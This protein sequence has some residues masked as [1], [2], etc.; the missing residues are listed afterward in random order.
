MPKY[1]FIGKYNADA[2]GGV[3][4]EGGSH[5]VEVAN[6]LAQSLGRR[7]EAF[8]FAFGPDDFYTIG[9]LPDNAAASA[10]GLKVASAGVSIRTVVLVEPA[11]VDSASHRSVEYTPPGG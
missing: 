3:L 5:R 2:S 4:K 9:D 1:M 8:Y 6:K 11:E 10:L 7:I